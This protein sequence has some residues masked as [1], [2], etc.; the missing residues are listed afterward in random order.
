MPTVRVSWPTCNPWPPGLLPL[1]AHLIAENYSEVA[2]R[3]I[4]EFALAHGHLPPVD[5]FDCPADYAEAFTFFPSPVSGGSSQSQY[6]DAEWA[7]R[8]KDLP[9]DY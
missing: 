8:M 1:A 5:W 2:R 6:T 4:L 3:E 7:R 9:D